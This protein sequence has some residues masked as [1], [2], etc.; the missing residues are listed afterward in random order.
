M[1]EFL[2]KNIGVVLEIGCGEGGFSTYLK[3]T[4]HCEVWGIEYEKE[5]GLVASKY[6]DKVLIGDVG[7]LMDQLPDHYFDTVICNDVLEHIYDPYTILKSLKTKMK[8]EGK[9]I[10]SIPNIRY[11]R[12]LYDLVFNKNW[13]YQAN[14]ILD[15][16][17]VR[18]F[19]TKSIVKM[20]ENAGYKVLT[21]KGINASKSIKPRLFN[22][23]TLGTFSDIKYI[24]FAT[25]AQVKL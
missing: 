19:T 5:Q 11:F 13:D 15:I 22:I 16:T 14:G 21:H 6:L 12:N 10:S 24:Q 17:H 7:Q 20:Y 25:V 8:A 3:N 1:M 2:P 9:V 4:Y 23:L 18:F